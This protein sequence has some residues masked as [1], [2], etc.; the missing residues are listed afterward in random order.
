MAQNKPYGDLEVRILKREEAGYPVEITLNHERQ[1]KR[2]Y[3]A[4]RPETESW[5]TILDPVAAGQELFAW[6]LAD[7]NLKEAWGQVREQRPHRIRLRID[8]DAPELHALP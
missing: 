1:F 3:L 5:E 2:G 4:P 6:F 7:G 8:R